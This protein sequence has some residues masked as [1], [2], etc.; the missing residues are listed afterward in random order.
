MTS[1]T[2]LQS[3]FE[4]VAFG[5]AFWGIALGAIGI[6]LYFAEAAFT[7]FGDPTDANG[8]GLFTISDVG[9]V[10]FYT[11][12]NIGWHIEQF[13][14][15]TDIGPFFELGKNPSG[16]FWPVLLTIGCGYVLPVWALATVEEWSGVVAFF[17]GLGTA[18][19][20]V[21]YAIHH[22]MRFIPDMPEFVSTG[23]AIAFSLAFCMLLLWAMIYPFLPKAFRER[24][25]S[26]FPLLFKDFGRKT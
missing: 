20:A 8:D 11:F 3:K 19:Y 24:L 26:R 10:A 2:Q 7:S 18:L 4:A 1:K 6:H 16:W 17:T 15:G 12:T 25:K 5:V 22:A 9:P 14:A 23:I 21:T 13:L